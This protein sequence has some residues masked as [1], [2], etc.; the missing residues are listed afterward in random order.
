MSNLILYLCIG[1]GAGVLSGLF[2]IGGGIVIVPMLVAFAGMTQLTAQGTSLGALLLP[3]GV[4][5]AWKYF[6][7][8]NINVRA[9]LVIALSLTLGALIGAMIANHLPPAT[10]K[11]IFGAFLVFVGI[12]FLYS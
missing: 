8:G 5:G 12:R 3:V 10:M 1:L 2:G 11:K 9:S 7:E 6:N 4:L